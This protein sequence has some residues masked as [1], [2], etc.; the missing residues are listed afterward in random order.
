[1]SGISVEQVG[2]ILSIKLDIPPVNALNI[3]RYREIERTFRDV[4]AGQGITCVVL[5]AAGSRAFCAGMDLKE[6]RAASADDD[7]ARALAVR[8]AFAA[9]RRCPIPVIAAVGGAAIGAGA[10]LASVCDIR[11]ASEKAYFQMTEIDVGRCGGGAHMGRHVPP[12]WLRLMYFTGEPINVWQAYS[13]GFVQEVVPH[14]RL[15]KAAY[16]LAEVVAA[17]SEVGLRMA[18][19][20]LNQVEWMPVEE[21]Y[22]VE[23]SYSTALMKLL[24]SSGQKSHQ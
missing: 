3:D 4:N 20:A 10:V 1:V 24:D 14:R 12:G 19:E 2:K 22:E 7:P 17:K 6:F 11:I 5:S 8:S 21:G 15:N 23:Q 16:E 13:I 9:V 18:K